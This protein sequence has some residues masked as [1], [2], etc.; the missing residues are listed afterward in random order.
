[1]NP[2]TDPFAGLLTFNALLA[3]LGTVAVMQRNYL[4]RPKPQEPRK[5]KRL[6]TPPPGMSAPDPHDRNHI[7]TGGNT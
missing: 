1:V 4:K 2:L 7:V 6:T 3:V 5:Q